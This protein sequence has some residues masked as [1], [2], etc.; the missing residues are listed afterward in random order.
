MIPA[1]ERF[2]FRCTDIFLRQNG[3]QVPRMPPNNQ[4]N[5]LIDLTGDVQPPEVAPTVN[6]P[7]NAEPNGA[8]AQAMNASAS[9]AMGAQ[10]AAVST[11]AT[12][13]NATATAASASAS[14]MPATLD[15]TP[16]TNDVTTASPVTAIVTP[17]KANI[18]LA[19][20]KDGPAAG[21]TG[22]EAYENSFT[23]SDE[24]MAN[25]DLSNLNVKVPVPQVL[26]TP[27]DERKLPEHSKTPPDNQA[28]TSNKER[29]TTASE[30]TAQGNKNTKGAPKEPYQG[31]TNKRSDDAGA[32]RC[33]ARATK[34]QDPDLLNR[35]LF[36]PSKTDSSESEQD[37]YED[38]SWCDLSSKS[39]ASS[40]SWNPEQDEG[41]SNEGTSKSESS[42]SDSTSF[43]SESDSDSDRSKVSSDNEWD[44]SKEFA[45][46]DKCNA[47][48]DDF[49]E[50]EY[51][52]TEGSNIESEEHYKPRDRPAGKRKIKIP[53]SILNHRV[54]KSVVESYE[55]ALKKGKVKPAPTKMACSKEPMKK[56]Q[57]QKQ[58]SLEECQAYHVRK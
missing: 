49:D 37:D 3:M 48:D 21:L 53:E 55:R 34:C 30:P 35:S 29:K 40:A 46:T 41:S 31:E 25:L 32:Q 56:K 28:I 44:F 39:S 12:T 15:A 1:I 27:E 54:P 19:A 7:N 33:L 2:R 51:D 43:K 24:E 5:E 20:S 16:A 38:N 14:V 45:Y 10:V 50:D 36:A 13:A 23:T 42:K 6:V 18:P 47:F 4:P 58:V 26:K 8:V 22:E 57:K 52:S 9:P 17:R 11:P